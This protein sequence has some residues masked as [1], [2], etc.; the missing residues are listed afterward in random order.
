MRGF[1]RFVSTSAVLGLLSFFAVPAFGDP[2]NFSGKW[3][4]DPGKSQDTNGEAIELTIADTGDKIDYERIIHESNGKERKVS[5]SCAP[6]GTWCEFNEEGHKAKVSIWH[7]G[8]ALM[9]AKEGGPNS[10]A[11]T[12]RRL[13]LSADGKTL[14]VEFTNFSGTSKAQKLVFNKQ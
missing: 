11:T 14:T 9:M 8:S 3:V 4:L 12:E 5:F 2:P 1:L 7:D 6:V 13:E 10:D